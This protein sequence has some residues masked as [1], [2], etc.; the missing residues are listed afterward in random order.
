[1]NAIKHKK[2]QGI[3]VVLAIA[4]L[5]VSAMLISETRHAA[6]L[7]LCYMQTATECRVLMAENAELRKLVENREENHE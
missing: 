1:M 7:D 4:L 6:E 2:L 5:T 3:I